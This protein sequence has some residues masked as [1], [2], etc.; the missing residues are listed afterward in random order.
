MNKRCSYDLSHF[1]FLTGRI[2]RLQTLSVMPVVAGDSFELM[3]EGVFRLSPLRRQLVMDCRVDLMAFYIPHRHIYG[4]DW[5]NFIR[6]G[7]DETLNL[8][9][10]TF[11]QEDIGC[12]GFNIDVNKHS[13]FNSLPRW[14]SRGYVQIWN[15]YFR[16]PATDENTEDAVIGNTASG[17]FNDNAR[18]YG[19]LCS[20]I[21][22][23]WNTGMPLS[24]T[25][26]RE[27]SIAN[28]KFDILD[29]R[30]VKARYKTE[31]MRDWF[32]QRYNDLLSQTWNS[33]VNIDADQRPEL[34][35]R[36]TAYLSG[37]DVDGTDDASLGSYSGK[38]AS[39][40]RFGFPRKYF[41]EH[42]A[43]WIMCLLRFPPVHYSEIHPLCRFSNPSYK[44]IA[45]DPEIYMSEPPEILDPAS[46]WADR[47]S[48]GTPLSRS[49]QIGTGTAGDGQSR[50]ITRQVI[51]F[52]QHYRYHPSRVHSDFESVQGFPFVNNVGFGTSPPEVY[53]TDNE[54]DSVFQTQQLAQWQAQCRLSVAAYRY[55]PGP[56]SSIFA[57]TR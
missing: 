49:L 42:G 27:I 8:P 26:D 46:W 44:Q 36:N 29:L 15:R 31:Q 57:G 43:V 41:V 17:D 24:D 23:P 9:V 39:M 52:G 14:L 33:T 5:V 35:V 16:H 13:T 48:A 38:A 25:A 30:R 28:N 34:L 40:V 11:T 22:R 20:R 3:L 54:Y 47:T 7:V 53:I 51:P 45:G 12:L 1:S 6:Q 56:L 37:Y 55:I 50:G 10:D 19:L 21:K 4:D 18:K 32:G 2:G